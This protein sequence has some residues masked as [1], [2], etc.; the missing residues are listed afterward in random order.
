MTSS[1]LVFV[2][3]VLLF[4]IYG[5]LFT[6]NK[7]FNFCLFSGFIALLYFYGQ[8]LS[9]F[10]STKIS[11]RPDDYYIPKESS[12][13]DF[14]PLNFPEGSGQYWLYGKD[15]FNYYSSE[16][17]NEADYVYITH[18]EAMKCV[19]FNAMDVST[20]CVHHTGYR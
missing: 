9:N 14:K 12:L 8:C 7:I 6:K 3:I 16:L 13:C 15:K 18:K 19:Q 11:V 10:A 4:L 1:N 2:G 17:I 20:W 5:I